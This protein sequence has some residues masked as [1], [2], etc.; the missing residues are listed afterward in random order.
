MPGAMD[1]Q[2]FKTLAVIVL[3]GGMLAARWLTA[4]RR[5]QRA[6]GAA[7]R[8][9]DEIETNDA[10]LISGRKRGHRVTVTYSFDYG[11]VW[12]LID[13]ELPDRPLELA[14]WQKNSFGTEQWKREGR[15]IDI[16]VGDAAFDEQWIV[17][18]APADVVRRVVGQKVRDQLTRLAPFS[19]YQPRPRTLQMRSKGM[20]ESAWIAEGIDTVVSIAEAIEPA[21]EAADFN[22]AV[23][24]QAHGA[25]YRGEIR[26]ADASAARARELEQLERARRRRTKWVVGWWIIT[27]AAVAAFLLLHW[28]VS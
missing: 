26:P 3:G 7:V 10:T 5:R 12:T 4:Q 8:A 25:P 20:R 19:V 27:G 23:H 17:E 22:A 15:L 2:T 18:G 6:L 28:L 1:S 9:L 11:V 13:C 16:E 14:L 24:A 21:F